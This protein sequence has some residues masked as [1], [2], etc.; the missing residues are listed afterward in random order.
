M[1]FLSVSH[2]RIIIIIIIIIIIPNGCLPTYWALRRHLYL[3]VSIKFQ[4]ARMFRQKRSL[5]KKN[6]VV[7]CNPNIRINL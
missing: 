6:I 1:F 4:L 5:L 7:H 2:F 3:S